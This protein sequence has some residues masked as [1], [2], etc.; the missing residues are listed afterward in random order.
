[1]VE[2]AFLFSDFAHFRYLPGRK[3][4]LNFFR[5]IKITLSHLQ[6]ILLTLSSCH[7]LDITEK[8]RTLMPLLGSHSSNEWTLQKQKQ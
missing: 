7:I 5:N 4:I 3:Q 1:M 6:R 2:N 8:W